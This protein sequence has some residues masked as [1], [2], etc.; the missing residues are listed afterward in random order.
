VRE[1]DTA[2]ALP[3]VPGAALYPLHPSS[4][5]GAP[6]SDAGQPADAPVLPLKAFLRTQEQKHLNRV[7]EQ[8]GGDKEQAAILLGVSVATLYR[9]LS[10]ED[11]E[12]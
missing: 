6:S 5:A 4:G 2:A 12:S 3:D 7:L 1:G 8:C 9:K 10:G 11:K